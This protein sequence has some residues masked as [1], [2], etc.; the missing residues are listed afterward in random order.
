MLS[1]PRVSEGKLRT[2]SCKC[3]VVEESALN[4][5]KEQMS[6]EAGLVVVKERLA[7]RRFGMKSPL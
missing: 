1:A 3:L 5:K 6:E 7:F 2:I 4:A